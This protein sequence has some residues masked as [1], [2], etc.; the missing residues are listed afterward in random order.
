MLYYITTGL[1]VFYAPLPLPLLVWFAPTYVRLRNWVFVLPS[2]LMFAVVWL[3][4]VRA[5]K[6]SRF[7]V[8]FTTLQVFVVYVYAFAAA[9]LDHLTGSLGEWVATGAVHRNVRFRIAQVCCGVWTSATTAATAYGI[10]RQLKIGNDWAN[11]A[12]PILA[13]GLMFFA[14]IPFVVARK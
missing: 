1:M 9:M 14:A 3:M 10:Y 6:I 8:T 12:L 5:H 11:F 4:F 2:V 7:T 13:Q